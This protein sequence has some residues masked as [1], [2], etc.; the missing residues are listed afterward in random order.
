MTPTVEGQLTTGDQRSGD[1]E[2]FSEVFRAN[3]SA[4]FRYLARRLGADL[5]EDL[6]AETFVRALASWAR[7]D[8]HRGPVRPWLFGIA[9][10]LAREHR[11]GEERQLAAYAR[12]GVDRLA[13]DHEGI[14]ARLDARGYGPALAGALRALSPDERDVL[15]LLAWGQLSYPEIAQAL[16]VPIGTVRSRLSRARATIRAQLASI[17]I[18]ADEATEPLRAARPE[19]SA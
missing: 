6:A 7:Y 15:L 14:E 18:G 4:V 10:N 13:L 3:H 9:T 19:R 11:R 17:E 12:H 5:A 8:A 1:D 16:R 2:P